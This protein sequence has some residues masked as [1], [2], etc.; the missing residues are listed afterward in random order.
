MYRQ[1][2]RE[3][4]MLRYVGLSKSVEVKEWY[5]SDLKSDDVIIENSS[6]L[7]ESPMQRRQM[8]FD[9]IGTGI[10]NRPETNP[11]TPEAQQKIFQLLEF[12]HWETAAEDI[13]TLQRQ[14][15]KR[16]NMQIME[17]Q[18]PQLM[19]FDDDLIHLEMHDRMRMSAEYEAVL[20]SPMG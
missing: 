8:V 2:V 4:R 3:P 18:M 17:G 11:F 12:G 13:S 14:R 10:F 15:A 6:A 5:V 19:D 16:E 20:K 9:L 7:A 1:F